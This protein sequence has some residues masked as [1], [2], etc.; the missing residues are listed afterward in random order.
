[1]QLAD[2]RPAHPASA[3]EEVERGPVPVPERAPSRLVV[4]LG[5]GVLDAQVS[6][7]ALDARGLALVLELRRVDADELEVL[8]ATS[9][10]RQTAHRR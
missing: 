5:N 10:L 7:R 8:R 6:D 1:M 4:V 2:V 9:E 3:I